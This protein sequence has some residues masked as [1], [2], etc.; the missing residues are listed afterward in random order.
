VQLGTLVAV[1]AYFWND[2]VGIV[3]GVLLGL[4]QR[5]PLGTPEARLGWLVFL[6]TLPAG[7]TLLF[8]DFL[9]SVFGNPVGTASLLLVT[10][11]LLYFS[12]R[13]ARRAR[14]LEALTWLDAALIGF[15]QL[16]AVFPGVSRSG[17]TIAGGLG[18]GLERAEAARFSFLMSVPALLAAGLIAVLDLL[19]LPNLAD[20]LAPILAGFAAAAVVGYLSIRWLLGYLNRNSLNGFAAYCVAASVFCLL[21]AALR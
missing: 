4:V 2:L 21:V 8:K 15:M 1:F 3:R 9:E 20:Y 16:A 12:E 14:R 5:R 19:A 6:A 18:R 7:L 13:A 17:A 10:A 11:A